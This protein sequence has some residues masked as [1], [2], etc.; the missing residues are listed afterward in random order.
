MSKDTMATILF[1][2]ISYGANRPPYAL[3]EITMHPG[4]EEQNVTR[5]ELELGCILTMR[6]ELID[7]DKMPEIVREADAQAK[8]LFERLRRKQ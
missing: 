7:R 6:G 4:R 2:S 1:D 5:V 3:L 8:K